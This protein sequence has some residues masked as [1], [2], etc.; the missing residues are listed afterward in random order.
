MYIVSPLITR[1]EPRSNHL[2]FHTFLSQK[3]RQHLPL[4]DNLPEWKKNW[5]INNKK[6][7]QMAD[8][9]FKTCA[10]PWQPWAWTVVREAQWEEATSASAINHSSDRYLTA[11]DGCPCIVNGALISVHFWLFAP[12][13]NGPWFSYRLFTAVSL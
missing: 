11:D 4:G 12:C 10:H 9:A 8:L 5:E 2:P 3:S 6:P 7:G 1:A 13:R